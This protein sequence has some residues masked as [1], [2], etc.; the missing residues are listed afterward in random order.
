LKDRI[1]E[2]ELAK[3]SARFSKELLAALGG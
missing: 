3:V 1:D 2:E